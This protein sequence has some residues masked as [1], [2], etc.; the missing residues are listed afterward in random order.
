MEDIRRGME[1]PL[2][3]LLWLQF[4]PKTALL[5]KKYRAHNFNAQAYQ[6]SLEI[7]FASTP[8]VV[9]PL[10]LLMGMDINIHSFKKKKNV[11]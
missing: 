11:N 2:P 8:I 9:G 1:I 4:I 5:V 6:D 10:L 3:S 7:L